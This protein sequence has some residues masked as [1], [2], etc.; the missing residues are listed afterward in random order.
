MSLEI[1]LAIAGFAFVMSASPGPSN[2]LLLASGVNFGFAR[3]IPLILGISSGFLTMVF[4]LGIGLGQVLKNAPDIYT[5]LKVACATYV[6]WLAWKIAR[7]RTFGPKHDE[8][9][10]HPISYVQAALFQ[11]VNPKAWAVALVVTTSYTDPENYLSSLIMVIIMFAVINLP[12]ISIWAL[13]GVALRRILGE[14]DRIVVFNVAMALLLVAS[15][16]VVLL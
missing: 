16:A 4:L 2:F 11:L 10:G 15:M 13:S 3:S 12:S 1:G 14:G 7:S 6:M 8:E 5:L 9:V